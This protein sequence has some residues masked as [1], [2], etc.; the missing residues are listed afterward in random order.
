M[1]IGD[2]IREARKAAGLTQVELAKKTSLSR[3]YIGDIEKNRYNPS[4]TTLQLIATATGTTMAF[5]LDG[6]EMVEPAPPHI[7]T[8]TRRQLEKVLDDDNLT[9][10]GVVLKGED[11]EKVK[12]ALE[13][14]FWDVKE[15]N[16]RKK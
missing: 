12:K 13:L 10:N 8:R 11:K 16:R 15:K 6:A 1:A 3:S 4:V 2:K 5:L 9:Y 7:D 14:I